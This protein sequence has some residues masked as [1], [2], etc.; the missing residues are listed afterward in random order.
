MGYRFLVVDRDSELTGSVEMMFALLGHECRSIGNPK[1][2]AKQFKQFKPN[3]VFVEVRD[4]SMQ[5]LELLTKLRAKYSDQ[6]WLSFLVLS[7]AYP[8][9]QVK[10]WLADT[11]SDGV[12]MKPYRVT[13]LLRLV[14]RRVRKMQIVL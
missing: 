8:M 1:K 14:E 10:Q 2:I 11:F 13:T 5:T 6:N 3:I 12:V 9:D 7:H 4:D